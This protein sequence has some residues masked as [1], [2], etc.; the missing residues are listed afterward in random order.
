MKLR[1]R[2]EAEIAG[3]TGGKRG[4]EDTGGRVQ[5]RVMIKGRKM[6]TVAGADAS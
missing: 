2:T 3:G 5:V 1:G 6:A 4:P